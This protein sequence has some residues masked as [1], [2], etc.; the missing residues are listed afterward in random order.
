MGPT[1]E[2]VRV[3]SSVRWVAPLQEGWSPPGRRSTDRATI[4]AWAGSSRSGRSRCVPTAGESPALVA[5]RVRS[6][7]ARR[8]VGGRCPG[9]GGRGQTHLLRVRPPPRCREPARAARLAPRWRPGLR[10]EPV[11]RR[12]CTSA[13]RSPDQSLRRHP[14]GAAGGDFIGPSRRGTQRGRCARRYRR[15]RR[16]HRSTEN[17]VGTP[18]GSRPGRR[19]D[20]QRAFRQRRRRRCRRPHRR[21]DLEERRDGQRRSGGDR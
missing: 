17:A 19:G 15:R 11:L 14:T 20:G 10:P 13:G 7:A 4:A 8:G 3:E 18:A 1:T 6:G 5:C 12:P 16:G 2:A 21:R 9:H